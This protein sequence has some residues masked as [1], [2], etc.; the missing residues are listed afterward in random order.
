MTLRIIRGFLQLHQEAK[1][2]RPRSHVQ[3]RGLDS[4]ADEADCRFGTA[5]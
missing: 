2:S 3:M 5:C 4:F 1:K